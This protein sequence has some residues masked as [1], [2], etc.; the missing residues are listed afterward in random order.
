M[1]GPMLRLRLWAVPYLM[2]TFGIEHPPHGIVSFIFIG[3]AVGAP[4]AGLLSDRVRA[5][6]AVMVG[7]ALLSTVS[8][9]VLLKVPACRSPCSAR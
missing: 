4:L 1:T 3:W 6:K 9:F 7:G 2:A 8:F 5:R